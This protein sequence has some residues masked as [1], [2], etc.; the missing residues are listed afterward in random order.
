MLEAKFGASSALPRPDP[1]LVGSYEVDLVRQGY[2]KQSDKPRPRTPPAIHALEERSVRML[3]RYGMYRQV[4]LGRANAQERL[5]DELGVSL[6]G[7]GSS[8]D[9]SDGE[10]DDEGYGYG[11]DDD[12]W[13]EADDDA[14]G[15][16][17][18]AELASP[19]TMRRSRA[20]SGGSFASPVAMRGRAD[21]GSCSCRP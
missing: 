10:H 15:G 16:E 6:R 8:F 9:G 5:A 18:A 14:G 11:E 7:A 17:S 13:S 2:S 19:A 12:D 21:S 20:D 4:V 1:H 3:L